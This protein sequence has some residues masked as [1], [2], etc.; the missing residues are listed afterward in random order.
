MTAQTPLNLPNKHE[1]TRKKRIACK[2]VFIKAERRTSRVFERMF[3]AVLND[4][5]LLVKLLCSSKTKK[6]AKFTCVDH[7][8][9]GPLR[10]HCQGLA[11]RPL[12]AVFVGCTHGDTQAFG[13]SQTRLVYYT[14]HSPKKSH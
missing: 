5:V 6:E 14:R 3:A 12:Q 1:E 11:R 8:E 10:A 4:G 2:K 13:G 9:G 7:E